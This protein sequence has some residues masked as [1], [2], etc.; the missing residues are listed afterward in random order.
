MFTGQKILG[1]CYSFATDATFTA[2][3]YYLLNVGMISRENRGI[4]AISEKGR[5]YLKI[6]S[7]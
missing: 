4:Y 3:I 7:S 2:Q 1:T 5:Q 6:M